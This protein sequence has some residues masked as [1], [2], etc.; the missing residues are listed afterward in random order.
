MPKM[1][2]L[3][4]LLLVL[5]G[6]KS[7]F[8]EQTHTFVETGL[9][10]ETSGSMDIFNETYN[11]NMLAL[12]ELILPAIKDVNLASIISKYKDISLKPEAARGILSAIHIDVFTKDKVKFSKKEEDVTTLSEAL[13]PGPNTDKLTFD[14]NTSSFVYLEIFELTDRDLPVVL[15]DC[16]SDIDRTGHMLLRWKF[17]DGSYINWETTAG[18]EPW[19]DENTYYN[20]NCIEVIPGSNAF[21]SRFYSDR[22]DAKKNA[23]DYVGAITAYN[24]AV[25]LDQKNVAVYNNRGLAKYALEDYAGAVTDFDKAIELNSKDASAYNNRGLAKYYQKDYIGAK[26]DLDRAIYLNPKDADSYTARGIVKEVMKDYAGAI[27]DYDEAFKLDPEHATNYKSIRDIAK[28]ELELRRLTQIELFSSDK[29][30]SIKIKFNEKGKIDSVYDIT[31]GKGYDMFIDFNV[32]TLNPDGT[33]VITS[34]GS[35][36]KI[37]PN[38]ETSSYRVEFIKQ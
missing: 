33:F 31:L 18:R 20:S 14:C 34:G 25:E 26:A 19:D 29:L 6:S 1:L 9:A 27:A 16:P 36:L 10:I 3:L 28:V 13:T 35:D 24:R 23:K 7:L 2:T 11:A 12:N 30:Y 8:A 32:K 5:M 4:F 37:I 21:Y 17:S 22:G 38:V 15:L